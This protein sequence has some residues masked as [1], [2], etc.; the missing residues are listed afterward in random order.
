MKNYFAGFLI[1]SIFSLNAQNQKIDSLIQV[2]KIH[3]RDTIRINTLNDLSWEYINISEFLKADSFAQA[4]LNLSQ[5][6]SLS[7]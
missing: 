4:S 5:N 1:F 2:L 6:S 3:Q 7:L